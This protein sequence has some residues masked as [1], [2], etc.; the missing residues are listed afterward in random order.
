MTDQLIRRRVTVHGRVQ[1]VFFR[2]RMRACADR[3]GVAGWVRNCT[4]GSVQAVLEGEPAAV[5]RV[6]EFCSVGPRAAT[7]ERI[8]VSESEPPEGLSGF[9]IR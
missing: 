2:D 6:I 7:V 1:G 5:D 3:H 8:E 9:E 4:D